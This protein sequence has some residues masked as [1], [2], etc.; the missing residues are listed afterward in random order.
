ML[1]TPNSLRRHIG[2]AGQTNAGKSSLFNAVL[3]QDAAIV[4][5]QRGTTTDPVIKAMELIP[6]GPVV[7]VDTPGLSDD[8]GLG[9]RR[10]QAALSAMRRCDLLLLVMDPSGFEES[11]YKKISE[12]LP[13]PHLLVF[14]KSDAAGNRDIDRLLQSHPGAL[15][16][17]C[18]DP[19]SI[20]LLKARLVKELEKIEETDDTMIGDL[21]EPGSSVILVTPIDSEA[22]KGRMILPQVQ[23]IRDC[24]DHGIL[25]HVCREHELAAALDTLKRADLAVTD[26]Q[27]FAYVDS[28]IPKEMPLTSFSLLLARQ[29]GDIRQLIQGAAQIDRLPENP[30]I[31]ML[32]ACA[33]N[34]THEDIGRVKIPAMIRQR[35]GREPRFDYYTGYD[36]PKDCACYDLAVQCGGCM[37]NKREIAS[38]LRILREAQVPVTNY[39][40][41][42]AYLNGILDRCARLFSVTAS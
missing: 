15:A 42:L 39:G 40:V 21:L 12:E 10:M 38:R 14:S 9:S 7:L 35:T 8:T 20:H 36:F 4:S 16:V 23:L 18:K 26:S 1:K 11:L 29:K 19:A 30:R 17:S 13:A 28:V 27:A 22:P 5:P 6:F 24:L 33:H 3:G 31:L 34:H 25:C 41:A 37:I 32:E 2:F